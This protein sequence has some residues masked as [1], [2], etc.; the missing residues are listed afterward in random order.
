MENLSKGNRNNTNRRL[1]ICSSPHIIRVII[2]QT[3][4]RAGH[5]LRMGEKRNTY[6]VL[7]E[8]PKRDF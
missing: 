2:L 4:K 8:K 7:V 6:R 3:M 5:I 1:K